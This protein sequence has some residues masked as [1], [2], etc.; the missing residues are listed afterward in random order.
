LSTHTS[1]FPE[2]GIIPVVMLAKGLESHAPIEDHH[3]E[4]W[5]PVAIPSPLHPTPPRRAKSSTNST[6]PI[7]TPMDGHHVDSA[8]VLVPSP[9]LVLQNHFSPLEGLETTDVGGDPYIVMTHIHDHHVEVYA[10]VVICPTS[11]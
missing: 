3:V 10:H 7:N 4:V 9:L 8:I 1:D 2:Q 6:T 11:S 5:A